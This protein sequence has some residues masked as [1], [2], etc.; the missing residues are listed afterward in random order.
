[1]NL[2]PMNDEKHTQYE[3]A[4][5]IGLIP[6]EHLWEPRLPVARGKQCTKC[7]VVAPWTVA[8]QG[9]MQERAQQWTHAASIE[10]V[11]SELERRFYD[12][13]LQYRRTSDSYRGMS[14]AVGHARIIVS[15]ENTGSGFRSITRYDHVIVFVEAMCYLPRLRSRRYPV[16]KDGTRAWGKIIESVREMN[17]AALAQRERLARDAQIIK[18]RN[19]TAQR[20]REQFAGLL[21]VGDKEVKP[22][23]DTLGG[24]VRIEF[25][26]LNEE[27]ATAILSVL[28]ER[29]GK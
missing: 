25:S 13:G 10:E 27:Q 5:V 9:A 11:V 8:E 28:E 2:E 15:H 26:G 29:F 1:M 23:F 22:H 18:D 3:N 6:H 19:E 20:L 4:L 16:R 17:A 24:P 12:A 14:G 21:V 7:G